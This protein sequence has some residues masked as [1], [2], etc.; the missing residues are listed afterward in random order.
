MKFFI[1][2]L[3]C[4]YMGEKKERHQTILLVPARPARVP[5]LH[6]ASARV[7]VARNEVPVVAMPLLPMIRSPTQARPR[8]R[9][10]TQSSNASQGYGGTA[11]CTQEDP[12]SMRCVCVCVCVCNQVVILNS[13]PWSVIY[14]NLTHAVARL[15]RAIL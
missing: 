9:A 6:L 3:F 11:Q 5:A 12:S 13:I 2:Y 10:C 14:H 1:K 15:A 7:P 4:F 8:T